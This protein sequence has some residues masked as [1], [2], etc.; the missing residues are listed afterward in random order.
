MGYPYFWKHPYLPINRNNNIKNLASNNINPHETNATVGG[1]K[2]FGNVHPYLRFP[3][4]TIIFFSDGLVQPPTR[5][6]FIKTTHI[7]RQVQYRTS[8]FAVAKKGLAAQ[9][10]HKLFFF[11]ASNGQLMVNWRFG[12]G[13][14]YARN[15]NHRAPHHQLTIS[16][17]DVDVGTIDLVTCWNTRPISFN[18]QQK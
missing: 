12:F 11:K 15:P 14:G 13:F 5:M 10:H 7:A 1:F 18:K 3:F 6:I 8:T 17:N 9:D 16:W 2:L 4:W